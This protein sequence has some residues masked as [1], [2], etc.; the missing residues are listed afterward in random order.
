MNYVKFLTNIIIVLVLTNVSFG[1]KVTKKFK[2]FY[3]EFAL[4]EPMR[5]S[6][7]PYVIDNYTTK[8]TALLRGNSCKIQN[9]EINTPYLIGK[10]EITN[11]L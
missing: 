1:Q 11:I 4:I 5:V 2:A 6:F 7:N 3:N 9:V 10:K 8:D